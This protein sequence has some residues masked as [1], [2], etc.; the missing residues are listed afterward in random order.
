M[1]N[2]LPERDLEGEGAAGLAN[3]HD[4][5]KDA[6]CREGHAEQ[7]QRRRLLAGSERKA[8]G[9]GVLD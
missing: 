5:G 7:H 8:I 2:D 4:D 6:V 1:T 3:V 9:E